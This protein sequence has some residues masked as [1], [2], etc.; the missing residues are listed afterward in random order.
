MKKFNAHSD[1]LTISVMQPTYFP[2]LGY[3]NLIK[4]SDIFV[5]YDTVQLS[6]RSWQVRNRIKSSHGET[7]LTI[8]I[9]KTNS[10]D[11]LKLNKAEISYSNKWV[12]KHL[13]TISYSYSKT[14]YYDEIFPLIQDNLMR[15]PKYLTDLTSSM[16]I[17][18]LDI[19][20]IKTKIE[21]SS[22]L[23][24]EGHKAT[25]ILSICK[26]LKAENYLSVEGS[27]DYLI[28]VEEFFNNNKIK[29]VWHEYNH[30]IYNQINGDFLPYLG[31]IDAL[32]NI[33]IEKTREII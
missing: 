3:F 21:F 8:P 20:N 25:A 30:P 15:S 28:G 17:Q 19:L 16:L 29:I 13:S 1:G 11:L 6:K 4:K 23:N 14:P 5:I 26:C 18:F 22:N 9:R 27:K 31:V 10:R 24:F 33:G 12:Q 7:F 32:F 2:W